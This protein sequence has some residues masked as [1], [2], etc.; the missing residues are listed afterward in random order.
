M[1]MEGSSSSK[2]AIDDK[3]RSRDGREGIGVE[4]GWQSTAQLF[5][6]REEHMG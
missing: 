6:K 1:I 5:T 3:G 2:V 4:Y